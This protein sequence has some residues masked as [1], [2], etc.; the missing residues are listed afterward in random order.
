M[1]KSRRGRS[2]TFIKGSPAKKDIIAQDSPRFNQE[3]HDNACA[4]PNV[5]EIFEKSSHK[6]S[7]LRGHMLNIEDTTK[8][9]ME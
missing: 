2:Q 3:I 9:F 7:K 1:C 6:I 4:S 5:K 8:D